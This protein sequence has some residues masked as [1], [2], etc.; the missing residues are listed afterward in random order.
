MNVIETDYLVIGAGAA[1]MS[2][3]DALIDAD[4]DSDVVMV[5]RRP[6]PGGHWNDAYPFVRLHQP[7]AC[8][9]VNSRSLGHDKLDE[10]GLNAGLY[11]QADG[12]E[13]CEYFRRVMDEHHL[14]SGQVRFFPMSNYLGLETPDVAFVAALTGA[15]T[16]VQVRQAVVD[17]RYLEPTIPSRHTPSFTV[18]TDVRCIPV[19]ELAEVRE[20]ATGYTIIGGG[21]TGSDACTWLLGNGVDPDKIRWIRARDA[22]MWN[23]A[24]VQPLELVTDTIDG[25]SR[26]VE[27]SA[28][29]ESVDD[30][31]ARLEACGQLLRFDPGVAPTMYHAATLTLAEL[32]LLRTVENVVRL[33][34][35][36]TISAHQIVL[37]QGTISTDRGQ[38]YV[39]C[40]AAGLGKAPARPIF[41]PG[42]ITLQCISTAFPTFNAAV[43]GY[44][45]A[46]RGDDAVAKS[47]LSPT[48]RYPDAA[49]DW[50]PN[51]RGQLES[52]GLWNE[53]PDMA[54]WLASSRLN[55]ARGMFEKAG[56]P[57]MAEAITRL[58]TY[59]EPAVV[60]LERLEASPT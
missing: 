60:N 54:A 18:D 10:H 24:H 52:L 15:T 4:R 51:M 12:V 13:I 53:Q 26:G 11:Q 41:E 32:E 30:L 40:S 50:I 1:G 34:H 59:T 23:R 43:I 47:N 39:D 17:A 48:N 35:I 29:A 37:E 57:P 42:R 8:Y 6:A 33:G 56:E 28:E 36:K 3:T 58:L 25:V 19:N 38:L 46:S 2:F 14:A 5:D 21:K 55:I 27:A 7:A 16:R 44:L 49:Q 22:W 9:G 20:P 31:F 45:E